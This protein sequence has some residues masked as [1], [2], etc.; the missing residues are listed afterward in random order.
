MVSE[1]SLKKD[2]RRHAGVTPAH[3]PVPMGAMMHT[4]TSEPTIPV[5]ASLRPN[6]SVGSLSR[7]YALRHS[8]SVNC[9]RRACS[10][11][12]CG[13]M[14][15]YGGCAGGIEGGDGGGKHGSVS[16]VVPSGRKAGHVELMATAG[17]VR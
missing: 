1:N 7:L 2:H 10:A 8:V 4:P 12:Q 13:E 16:T 3:S 5:F 11:V 6:V 14:G 17:G 15:V 9:A